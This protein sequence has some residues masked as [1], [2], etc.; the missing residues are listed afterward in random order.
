MYIVNVPRKHSWLHPAYCCSVTQSCLT[1]CD[2]TDCS[3]PGLS[4][5][6][7]LLKF[8]QCPCSCP[9]HQR[10]HPAISSSDALFSFCPQS[11]PALG[12][13]P[14]SQLFISDKQNIGPSASA[15]VLP[16]IIQG[17]LPL[18][19]IYLNIWYPCYPK[20]SQESSPAPQFKDIN[21][22]VLHL[23]GSLP[24]C[25]ERAC[26]T[27][28]IYEPCHANPRQIGHGGDFWQNWRN[29]WQTTPVYLPWEPHELYKRASNLVSVFSTHKIVEIFSISLCL[30]FQDLD[31]TTE[32]KYTRS[33]THSW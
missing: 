19:L 31:G 8:A 26:V 20:D 30:K 4:V 16:K 18:R 22:S 24:C 23:H 10:C 7:H 14:M 25:A 17:L 32:Q 21:S 27:R 15:S 6:H 11:F 3:M 13:F 33:L 28:W 1:L 5:P 9:L 2:S 29:E 12:T